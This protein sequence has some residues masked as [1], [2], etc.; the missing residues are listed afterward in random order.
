MLGVKH[1]H[2]IGAEKQ[3]GSTREQKASA[4]K[5]FA[6]TSDLLVRAATNTNVYVTAVNFTSEN[7]GIQNIRNFTLT[8][9][10]A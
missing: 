10:E 6:F 4:G 5:A 2:G 9:K 3:K 1:R 7:V 8:L